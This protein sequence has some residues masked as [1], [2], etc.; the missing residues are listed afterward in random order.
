MRRTGS[1]LLLLAVAILGL[2]R[3]GGLAAAPNPPPA[4]ILLAQPAGGPA[5]APREQ[6]TRKVRECFPGQE[7]LWATLPGGSSTSQGGEATAPLPDLAQALA[8]LKSRGVA[9]VAV[10]S[11]GVLP[12]GAWEQQVAD[13]QA[14]TGLKIAS[15]KPL[16]SSLAD[17]QRLLTA[18]A[19]AFGRKDQAVLLVGGGSENP[20]A[21]REYLALYTLLLAKFKGNNLFFGNSNSLPEL[22]TA[23]AAIKK[24]PAG[25]VIIVPL[26]DFAD[27]PP[28]SPH[29]EALA[30]AKAELMA[31]KGPTV[32]VYQEGLGNIDGILAIYVDHLAAAL[33]ALT[34][35]KPE[36][37]KKGKK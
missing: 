4:I 18:L 34:P 9:Q 28:S 36:R 26:P 3:P 14:Q 12:G 21:L 15:G 37:K 6:F 30:A 7:I 1:C 19:A 31:V 25:S 20:A 17:R 5:A 16:L 8:A 10:Q 24:S 33:E 27:A 32:T 13:L 29:A 2:M 35:R 22:K 23:L 11:L